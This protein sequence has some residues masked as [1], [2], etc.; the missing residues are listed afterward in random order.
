LLAQVVYIQA[1]QMAAN[2]TAASA[3]PRQP[4]CSTIRCEICVS[5]KT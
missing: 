2:T 4:G 3:S 1:H 5:A